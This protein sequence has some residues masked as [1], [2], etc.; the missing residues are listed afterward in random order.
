MA[1]DVFISYSRKAAYAPY[2]EDLR[3]WLD[4]NY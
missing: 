1:T 2:E 4:T 3:D